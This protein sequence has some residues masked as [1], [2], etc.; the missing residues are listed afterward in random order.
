MTAPN[1]GN[2]GIGSP[3]TLHIH[4]NSGYDKVGSCGTAKMTGPTVLDPLY[5][6]SCIAMP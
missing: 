6:R 3:A 4:T 1:D 5:P 2:N